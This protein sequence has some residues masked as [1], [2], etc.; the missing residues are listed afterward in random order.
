MHGQTGNDDI[1]GGTGDD[2]AEGGVGS[3]DIFG[4]ADQ[5]DLVGGAAKAAHSDVADNLSGG[6]GHDVI[7]GDNA[8]ITRF[9]TPGSWT[10]DNLVD[11]PA[12]RDDVLGMIRRRV[13]L[14]DVATTAAPTADAGASGADNIL[15]EG[16][17]D[18]AYGQGGADEMQGGE[19]D[20]YLEGGAG[21]DHIYGQSGQDDVIGG[22]GRSVSD[23]PATAA[24][25]RLDGAESL[26][27]DDDPNLRPLSNT[28]D[29]DV[30]VGD[31]ATVVRNDPFFTGTAGSGWV[32]NTFNAS[33]TRTLFLYDV[34]IGGSPAA[35]GTSGG[36]SIYGQS[37]DDVL[38]GQGCCRL[39]RR[40]RRRRLHGRKRRQRRDPRPD[41]Q[42]RH[43]RRDGSYQHRSG[44]RH[45]RP[46]RLRRERCP[47][48]LAST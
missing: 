14:F 16:G 2:H 40:Q 17:R 41:R 18:I 28:D 26:F 38:Y 43:H 25:G 4:E 35:P 3:D 12:R 22:T 29:F 27:G 30:V 24:N 20:D 15:G 42:R 34:G 33:I 8:A 39:H 31:N 45:E 46:S 48:G 32:V 6:P 5:D 19:L 23:S 7:A 44:H 11:R 37:A 1:Y 21:N 9:G 13:S 47:A 10:A 36:D